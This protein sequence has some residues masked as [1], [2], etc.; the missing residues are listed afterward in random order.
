MRLITTLE[1]A[2]ALKDAG[3]PQL[4]YAASFHGSDSGLFPCLEAVQCDMQEVDIAHTVRLDELL[5]RIAELGWEFSFGLETD[6]GDTIDG[7]FMGG[8]KFW[9]MS[10]WKSV[11]I[12]DHPN[13]GGFYDRT[14]MV[15]WSH[16]HD[17]LHVVV[18]ATLHVLKE[19]TKPNS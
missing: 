17:P 18:Q 16:D 2:Q 12:D 19:S 6:Q 9:G 14:R 15:G 1:E 13:G 5:A 7:E 3:F 8:A 11:K 4:C 10:I